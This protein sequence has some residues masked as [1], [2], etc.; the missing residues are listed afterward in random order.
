VAKNVTITSIQ[1]HT[2]TGRPIA[3]SGSLPVTV[4]GG[5]ALMVGRTASLPLTFTDAAASPAFLAVTVK[6]DNL[7]P[8]STV[9]LQSHNSNNPSRQ[10]E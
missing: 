4:P 1:A 3:Y 6:A 7:P 9:L 5:T 2:S 10:Q 8:F